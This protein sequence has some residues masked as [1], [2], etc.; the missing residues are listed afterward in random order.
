MGQYNQ[1][2][3]YLNNIQVIKKRCLSSFYF[4]CKYENDHDD[5]MISLIFI[6]TNFNSGSVPWCQEEPNPLPPFRNEPGLVFLAYY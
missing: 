5:V 3:A 1:L 2:Y 6:F 4:I